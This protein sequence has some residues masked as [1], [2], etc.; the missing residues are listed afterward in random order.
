MAWTLTFGSLAPRDPLTRVQRISIKSRMKAVMPATF[1]MISYFARV[2]EEFVLS[3]P[4][5]Q[6]SSIDQ[7]SVRGSDPLVS[8]PIGPQPSERGLSSLSSFQNKHL[9]SWPEAQL[10]QSAA[11]AKAIV[12]RPSTQGPL[13]WSA[14]NRTAL[15]VRR[16]VK[17]D[18][19]G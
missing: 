8:V 12:G 13:C 15:I 14:D 18:V 19:G 11:A 7:A 16:V 6:S 9:I 2:A 5:A 4:S 3:K 1:D 17:S 10:S